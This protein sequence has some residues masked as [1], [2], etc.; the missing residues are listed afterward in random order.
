MLFKREQGGDEA[1]G[2]PG[3]QEALIIFSQSTVCVYLQFLPN[4]FKAYILVT[5]KMAV[6]AG[7]ERNQ[8][9]NQHGGNSQ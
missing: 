8:V 5:I 6:H 9:K 2:P 1:T 3:C 4:R 7:G